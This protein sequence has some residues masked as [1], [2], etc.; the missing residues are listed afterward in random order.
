[1]T[2]LLVQVS[3]EGENAQPYKGATLLIGDV[4]ICDVLKHI[5][6]ETWSSGWT[7]GDSNYLQEGNF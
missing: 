6:Q 7:V 4:V 5:I 2:C 1:M 3:L